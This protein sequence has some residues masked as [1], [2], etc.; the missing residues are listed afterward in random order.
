MTP[1]QRLPGQTRQGLE[2]LRAW[3]LWK[4][5]SQQ[6]LAERAGTAKSTIVKLEN[7][8]ATANFVTVGKLSKALEI[9]REQLLHTDPAATPAER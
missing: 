7:G 5:Y 9:S 6:E 3:R 2:H 4:G 1:S 8:R